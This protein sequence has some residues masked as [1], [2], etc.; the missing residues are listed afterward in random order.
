MTDG[1]IG[2]AFDSAVRDKL[3]VRQISSSSDWI[4]L[5]EHVAEDI[6]AFLA[7]YGPLLKAVPTQFAS[8]R[9]VAFTTWRLALGD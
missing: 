1:R 5:L 2:P 7:I 9:P 8:L 4:R 6:A 3:S